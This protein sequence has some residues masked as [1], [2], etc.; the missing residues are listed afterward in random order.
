M[1]V[2]D[3]YTKFQTSNAL[4]V[5]IWTIEKLKSK[6]YVSLYVFY[7]HVYSQKRIYQ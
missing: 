1:D 5:E 2:T 4:F 7:F 3:M 6:K